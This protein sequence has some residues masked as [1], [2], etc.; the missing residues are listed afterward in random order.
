VLRHDRQTWSTLMWWLSLVGTIGAGIGVTIGLVRLRRGKAYKRLQR[1]HHTIG[2]II[3][4]FV[5]CWIFSGFLSMNDGRPFAFAADA[6]LF[7]PLHTFDFPPL[8]SH[9]SLRTSLIVGLCVCGLA[10]SLTGVTLAWR[11]LRMSFIR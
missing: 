3:A 11:R 5:L 10:F 8:S 4:P 7:R 1:W 9:P 2:L 6:R